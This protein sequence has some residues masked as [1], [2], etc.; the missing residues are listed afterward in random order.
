MKP[1]SSAGKGFEWPFSFTSPLGNP[2][3]LS[4]CACACARVCLRAR[5]C[6]SDS[7]VYL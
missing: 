6:C 3:V 7:G 4:L 1:H 2:K 5:A